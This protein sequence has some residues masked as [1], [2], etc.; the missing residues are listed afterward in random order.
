MFNRSRVRGS[1]IGVVLILMA[2]FPWPAMGSE[3]DLSLS[4]IIAA[5]R[6]NDNVLRDYNLQY[7][8]KRRWWYTTKLNSDLTAVVGYVPKS[9][10]EVNLTMDDTYR[11][12][13]EGDKLFYERHHQDHINDIAFESKYASDGTVYQHFY[14]RPTSLSGVVDSVAARRSVPDSADKIEAYFCEFR[15]R[16]VIDWLEGGLVSMQAEK[17]T[18]AGK[19]CRVIDCPAEYNAGHV[20]FWISPD[21]GFRPLKM[22]YDAPGGREWTTRITEISEVSEGIWLPLKG[23]TL[24]YLPDPNT[25]ARMRYSAVEFVVDPNTIQVNTDIDDSA[26]AFE[27]PPATEV[28]DRIAAEGYRVLPEGQKQLLYLMDIETGRLT[29]PSQAAPKSLLGKPLGDLAALGLELDEDT[30]KDKPILLVFFDLEQRPS[31]NTLVALERMRTTLEGQGLVVIGVHAAKTDRAA[32]D[33][34][35]GDQNVHFPVGMIAEDQ[36]NTRATWCIESLPW[37]ILVNDKHIVTAE[38]FAVADIETQLAK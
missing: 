24:I 31:R 9:E 19:T 10:A 13:V 25:G 35:L 32:L 7:S 5:V 22:E 26:F 38:G 8:T 1:R 36:V 18:I 4:D 12:S 14:H 29:P 23:E 28:M 16:P 37:L 15:D 34:W 33:R 21:C 3:E 27:F 20:T 2:V 6:H 11:W 17:E 30:L